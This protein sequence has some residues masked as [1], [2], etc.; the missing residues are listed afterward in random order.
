MSTWYG[1]EGGWGLRPSLAA[2][3]AP[4]K[5]PFC[6]MLPARPRISRPP[7]AA[8]AAGHPRRAHRRAAAPRIRRADAP[9]EPAALA[10]CQP[11]L[12]RALAP[13]RPRSGCRRPRGARRWAR[14][15]PR[16]GVFCRRRGVSDGRGPHGA[17]CAPAARGIHS[18]SCTRAAGHGGWTRGPCGGA[19]GPAGA[20]SR[21][22]GEECH[23]ELWARGVA[24]PARPTRA[25][26]GRPH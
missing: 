4:H 24:F 23:A 18:R 9:Q 20:H 2:W 19:G 16:H 15:A 17:E 3:G 12:G 8:D 1:R 6:P 14:L 22:R 25:A 11:R 26:P 7:P 10:R 21:A 13:R 5:A